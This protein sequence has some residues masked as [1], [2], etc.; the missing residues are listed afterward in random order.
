MFS[1]G[2]NLAKND[3]EFL[4]QEK[5]VQTTWIFRPSKLRRKKYMETTWIFR[6]AK[7]YRKSTENDVEIRRNLIFDVST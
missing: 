7:L 4:R 6:S 2:C 1:L 5:Y 3:V